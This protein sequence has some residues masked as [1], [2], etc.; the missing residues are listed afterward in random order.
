MNFVSLLNLVN[1]LH[2]M[3]PVNLMHRMNLMHLNQS[4]CA[5]SA[6]MGTLRCPTIRC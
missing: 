2:P 1:L 6:C 4:S 5:R 3:N